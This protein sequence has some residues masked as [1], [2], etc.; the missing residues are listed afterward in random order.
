MARS[1]R[2][3]CSDGTV[4]IIEYSS[5][6]G[7]GGSAADILSGGAFGLGISEVGQ[8]LNTILTPKTDV[9]LKNIRGAY[10]FICANYSDGDEIILVGFSR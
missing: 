10:S 3:T 2:R 1:L 7:S 8:L 6:V 4:Q 9:C 5:G